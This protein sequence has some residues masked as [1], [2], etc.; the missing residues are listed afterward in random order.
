MSPDD[1]SDQL[2]LMSYIIDRT[3]GATITLSIE[4]LMLQLDFVSPRTRV[5]CAR[6]IQSKILRA[7][8]DPY[9]VSVT[10]P[11]DVSIAWDCFPD[12]LISAL[13]IS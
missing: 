5:T 10:Q 11:F 13:F 3:S 8:V 6:L 4:E 9:M 12:L 2:A 7:D 1:L